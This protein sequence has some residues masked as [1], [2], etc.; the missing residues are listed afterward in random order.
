M[1]DYDYKLAYDKW[2]R[3]LQSA[4]QTRED[5]YAGLTDTRSLTANREFFKING[6]LELSAMATE[7]QNQTHS[8]RDYEE[9][10]IQASQAYV[11]IKFEKGELARAHTNPMGAWTDAAVMGM[12]RWNAA[13]KRA[14]ATGDAT[15]QYEGESSSSVKTLAGYGGGEQVIAVGGTSMTD[16]KVRA[17]RSRFVKNKALK[18]GEAIYCAI[19][20]EEEDALTLL[21]A[22]INHDYI[23]NDTT[24]SGMISGRLHG[25]TFVRDQDLAT[26]ASVRTCFAW[27]KSGI[28][29]GEQAG[30]FTRQSEIQ[31]RHYMDEFYLRVDNG[32]TRTR[33]TDVMI[34]NTT[35]A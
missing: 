34:I 32:G 8:A 30:V 26:A 31:D 5:V 22:Y 33:E 18:G 35:V 24:S 29:F 16:A 11:S 19:S 3:A 20:Q 27:V 13:V 28:L 21:D 2:D 7:D 10:Q 15:A 25:V 12:H 14:A 6:T 4:H 1:A 9:R 23:A 17:I